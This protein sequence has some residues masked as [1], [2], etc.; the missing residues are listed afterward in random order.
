MDEEPLLRV[1]R[2]VPTASE[3]AA[4]VAV[5]VSRFK[6]ADSAPSQVSVGAWVRSGRPGAGPGSWRASGLPR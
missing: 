6:P 4:L 1:V 2:G 5:L 3:V